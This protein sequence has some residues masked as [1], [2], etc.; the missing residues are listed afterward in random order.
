VDR[1]D[2]RGGR[3]PSPFADTR[4]VN[5]QAQAEDLL[6]R[7][8]QAMAQNDLAAAETLIAQAEA[9]GVSY[10]PLH[11]GDTPRAAMRELTERRAAASG[12]RGQRFPRAI[13]LPA[14]TS[15]W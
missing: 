2:G 3:G 12:Q 9:L 6:Q 8:R 14:P 13:L 11:F 7:A 1:V 5:K 4:A 15:R 10:G